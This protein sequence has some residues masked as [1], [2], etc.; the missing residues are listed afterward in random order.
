M[1]ES[2]GH[3]SFPD[4]RSTAL[5]GTVPYI[6]GCENPR[7]VCFHVIRIPVELPIVR[8]V[9]VLAQIRTGDDITRFVTENSDFLCPLCVWHAAQTKKKPTGF[10]HPLFAPLF[11]P[12]RN[13]PQS[14]IAMESNN[15][16]Q[17]EHFDSGAG[18]DS[19][20]KVLRNAFV[21]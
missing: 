14:L 7:N 19:I 18:A 10:F 13:R 2:Y 15:F 17:K 11:V 4:R 12:Q 5:N 8:V 1:D 20:D 6:T 3:R 16:S 21:Q 9:A